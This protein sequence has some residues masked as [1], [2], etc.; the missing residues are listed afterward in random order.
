VRLARQMLTESL[1]LALVGG[2]LGIALAY[3]G[4]HWLIARA[5]ANLPR[6]DEIGLD[7][8]VLWFSVAV[9][10]LTGIVFGFLPALALT[11]SDPQ[12]ALKPGAVTTTENRSA[13]QLRS[14]LIGVEV[15]IGTLLLITAGLLTMSMIRLLDVDKGFTTEHV[16]AA[17]VNLPPQSYPKETEKTEFY[18]KVIRQVESLPGIEKAAWISKLPIEGKERV[19]GIQLPG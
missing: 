12:Q 3:Y 6:I 11:Q 14:S 13:R 5:P 19:G 16:M 15:G 2:S 7:A 8:R 4:L 9:S 17:D 18:E 10:A 1:L